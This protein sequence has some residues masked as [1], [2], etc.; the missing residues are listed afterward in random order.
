MDRE[1]RIV[2]FFFFC[3]IKRYTLE[4]ELEDNLG[5]EWLYSNSKN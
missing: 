5:F 1:N 3:T 2:L 4:Y